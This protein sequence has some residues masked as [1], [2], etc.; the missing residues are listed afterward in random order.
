MVKL[1]NFYEILKNEPSRI[2]EDERADRQRHASRWDS[3]RRNQSALW[4]DSFVPKGN[5]LLW[6]E[7]SRNQH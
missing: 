4:A 7:F 1:E 6:V 3:T 5:S 2:E